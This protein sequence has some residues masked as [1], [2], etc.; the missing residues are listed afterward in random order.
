MSKIVHSRSVL[1][2]MLQHDTTAESP[3]QFGQLLA[4]CSSLSC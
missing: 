1:Q 2:T 4:Q 3:Q